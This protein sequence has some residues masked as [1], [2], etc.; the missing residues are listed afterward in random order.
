MQESGAVNVIRNTRA[1][2]AHRAAHVHPWQLS[3]SD[4]CHMNQKGA[5]LVK[6]AK[7]MEL[8]AEWFCSLLLWGQAAAGRWLNLLGSITSCPPSGRPQPAHCVQDES[9]SNKHNKCPEVPSTV[10]LTFLYHYV[11]EKSQAQAP[12][13]F[14]G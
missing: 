4:W 5:A 14:G 3:H 10:H 9:K 1:V 11:S 2:F 12:A 8:P 6:P 7:Q 13:L